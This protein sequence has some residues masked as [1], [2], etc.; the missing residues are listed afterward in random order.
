MLQR[1]GYDVR[2]HEH[3]GL[4]HEDL[5]E[6]GETVDWMLAHRRDTAPRR[7]RVRAPPG[8]RERPRPTGCGS[9]VSMNWCS[10]IVADAEFV[11]PGL[12]RLDTDNAAEISLALPAALRGSGPDLTVVWNGKRR[13]VPLQDGRATLVSREGDDGA[14]PHKTRALEGPLTDFVTTPFAVV[15]GTISGDPA[16]RDRC[17]EKGAEFS[18]LW[19]AWQHEKPR[20]MDDRDVTPEDEKQFSLLL[21]GGPDANLVSRQIAPGLP[22]AVA[23]GRH[24]RGREDLGAS[25][26]P[27][28]R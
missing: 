14:G 20:L 28:S 24:H 17:R 12:L 11:R 6:R 9:I 13:E 21:I 23:P 25:P 2:Y 1:W 16:M 26:T 19:Q 27:F 7:V 3:V 22:F 4:G 5:K 15:V 10:L 18:R 8:P